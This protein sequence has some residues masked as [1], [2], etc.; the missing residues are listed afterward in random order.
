MQEIILI[1]QLV[2][3]FAMVGIILFQRSE[4][5][6]LG[7]GGGN[8]MSARGTANFLTRATTI[9]AAIFL[10]LTLVLAILAS[11]RSATTS[12]FDDPLA[13]EDEILPPAEDDLPDLAPD[14]PEG[15]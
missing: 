15:N 5:G 8:M 6:A 4:G 9:L 10:S 13:L 1:I 11:Q 2:V 12:V 7:M 14:L 3:A